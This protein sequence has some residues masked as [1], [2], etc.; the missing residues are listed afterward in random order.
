MLAH[1]SFL[2]A[3]FSFLAVSYAFFARIAAKNPCW[4]SLSAFQNHLAARRYVRSTWNWLQNL[5][6]TLPKASKIHSFGNMCPRCFPRGSKVVPKRVPRKAQRSIFEGFLIDLETFLLGFWRHFKSTYLK[7]S[8][9]MSKEGR[10]YVRSTKNFLSFLD[11]QGSIFKFLTKN[12]RVV[13]S[14]RL[15][16]GSAV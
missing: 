14:F 1:F 6:R 8:S 13:I 9:H 10:R 4:H 11:A 2:G 5:P 12:W 3:F 7:T 15:Y 16:N